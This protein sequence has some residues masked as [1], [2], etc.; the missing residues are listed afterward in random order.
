[1]CAAALVTRGAFV[2]HRHSFALPRSRT[3]QYRRTFG[4]LSVTLWNDISDPELAGVGLVG[5]KSRVN[6]ILLV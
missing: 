2:A 1:M 6:V 5:F 4:P 3:S